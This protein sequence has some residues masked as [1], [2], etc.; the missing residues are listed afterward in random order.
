MEAS[1]VNIN[2]AGL[3]LIK[4]FEGCKLK[5]YRCPAGVWTIG[6]GHTSKSVKQGQTISQHQADT[7]L[8]S[9][10]EKFEEGVADLTSKT[11]LT[12]N[13]FAACVSLAFN[14]GITRFAS[15]TLYKKLM[16][17]DVEGA[18][19]EFSKWTLAGGKRMPGLVKR[20]E[21]EMALFLLDN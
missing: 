20:R 14:I 15:S 7:I 19:K 9:D 8:A 13:Q 10:I 5:A 16:K 1:F 12:E 18:A 6:F 3:D 4:K 21:A 2:A 11:T 17:G